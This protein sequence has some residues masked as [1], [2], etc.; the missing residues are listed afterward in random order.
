VLTEL[1]ADKKMRRMS[2][3]KDTHGRS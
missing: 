3:L 1:E 2:K